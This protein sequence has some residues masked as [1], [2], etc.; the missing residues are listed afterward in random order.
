MQQL[1]LRLSKDP[2]TAL[3]QIRTGYRKW[4][5]RYLMEC[6]NQKEREVHSIRLNEISENINKAF[7]ELSA[8]Y[9]RK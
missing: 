8:E 9:R 5:L 7:T 2:V 6:N 3:R 1:Q 4:V